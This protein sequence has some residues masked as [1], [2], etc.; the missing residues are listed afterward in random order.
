M[1]NYG[2]L[3]LVS[4]GRM[5]LLAADD[6]TVGEVR[7]TSVPVGADAPEDEEL[8]LGSYEATVVMVRGVASDGWIRSAAVVDQAG[9]I[10]SLTAL[11]VFNGP[12]GPP[13]LPPFPF[14]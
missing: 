3:G 6:A 9:P 1:N 5:S 13:K 10:L 12:D 14:A 11:A 7:L 4:G 2:Y 8:E